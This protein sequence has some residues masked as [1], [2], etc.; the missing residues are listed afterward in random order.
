[1][2]IQDELLQITNRLDYSWY[3]DVKSM[4]LSEKEHDPKT[5]RAKIYIPGRGYDP[6][7]GADCED[8]FIY[9]GIREYC[10]EYDFE[11]LRFDGDDTPTE[12]CWVSMSIEQTIAQYIN[13]LPIA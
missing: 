11:N 2:T 4:F 3:S 13:D 9:C 10:W 8:E 7:T 12:G 5:K 1:M 6:E